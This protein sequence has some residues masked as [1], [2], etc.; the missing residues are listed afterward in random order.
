VVFH[1]LDC[2]TALTSP[3]MLPYAEAVE[4]AQIMWVSSKP[5]GWVIHGPPSYFLHCEDRIRASENGLL[6]GWNCERNFPE[7]PFKYPY[8]TRQ[9]LL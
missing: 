2:C 3:V 8:K 1:G 9:Y 7:Y 6:F 5:E 4:Y